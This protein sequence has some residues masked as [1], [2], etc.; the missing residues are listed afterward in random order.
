MDFIL[1][2]I[3]ILFLLS[4]VKT[5]EN[6]LTCVTN[7]VYDFDNKTEIQISSINFKN[8]DQILKKHKNETIDL[9]IIGLRLSNIEHVKIS[10]SYI[11]KLDFSRNDIQA[12]PEDFFSI[13]KFIKEINLHR[14]SIS[15]L[16]NLYINIDKNLCA[17]LFLE[18]LDL[19]YNKITSLDGNNFDKLKNLK[20]LSLEFNN[21]INLIDYTSIKLSLKTFDL[22]KFNQV[23]ELK[24]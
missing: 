12:I 10:T 18:K 17:F 21:I 5:E 3:F 11:N 22:N 24:K 13:L 8:L 16:T 4:F 14:N 23:K 7:E 15:N 1:N 9:I 6:N 19:S 2:E 20:Y